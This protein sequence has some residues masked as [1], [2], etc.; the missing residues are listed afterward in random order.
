MP[1]R[2]PRPLTTQLTVKDIC[3]MAQAGVKL[4]T[5]DVRE[6]L[7]ADAYMPPTP[8]PHAFDMSLEDRI[9][10]RW[11][12]TLLASNTEETYGMRQFR[13][14]GGSVVEGGSL[15]FS[16]GKVLTHGDKQYVFIQKPGNPP[17]IIEDDCS[18]FPSDNLL[19]SIRLMI[20]NMPDPPVMQGD[21]RYVSAEAGQGPSPG[22][23]APTRATIRNGAPGAGLPIK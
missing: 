19:N 21:M 14:R 7:S 9:Y 15:P 18:L 10:H 11:Q 3:E 23:N 17:C 13:H 22:P 12:S 2:T 20:K 8:P 16:I 1:Y 4:E 5:K 6:L